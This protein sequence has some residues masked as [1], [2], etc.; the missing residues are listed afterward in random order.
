[1]AE[2]KKE[3]KKFMDDIQNNIKDKEDLEY[4]QQRFAKFLDVVLDQMDKILNYKEEQMNE[5][6]QMQKEINKKFEEMQK[7]VDNIEKD[8]YEDED[9]DF[10][11]ICPYCD[12]EFAI[13]LDEENTEIECPECNNII[14]LDWSGDLEEGSNDDNIESKKS[15]CSGCQGCGNKEFN[16][17]KFD[18][19][20]DM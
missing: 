5:L 17:D 11:I 6:E 15:G 1:M 9:Y 8:I 16:S 19:D 4:V 20:D 2:L 10:E 3:Y 12:C 14:E 13:N 18:E 7:T